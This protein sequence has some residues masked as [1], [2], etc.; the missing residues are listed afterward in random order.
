MFNKQAMR[1]VRVSPRPSISDAGGGG[2]TGSIMFWSKLC[3]HLMW[4][5]NNM[6]LLSFRLSGSL[7][8]WK[9]CCR[10]WRRRWLKEVVLN[11]TTRYTEE[12]VALDRVRTNW[13]TSSHCVIPLATHHHQQRRSSDDGG[14]DGQTTKR[15]SFK[16]EQ[17]QWIEFVGRTVSSEGCFPLM[18]A[19]FT[20]SLDIWLSNIQIDFFCVKICRMCL[21]NSDKFSFTQPR[22]SVFFMFQFRRLTYFSRLLFFFC[23]SHQLLLF[24]RK[25]N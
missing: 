21:C 25:K 22:Y 3:N 10:R 5:S 11:L 17:R 23:V 9:W 18:N 2:E 13:I 14:Q 1:S 8:G 24:S 7:P 20:S 12:V 19:T 6:L 4:W 16:I 15:A